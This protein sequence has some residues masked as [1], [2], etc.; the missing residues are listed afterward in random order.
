M[1]K[2]IELLNQ[3]NLK[4]IDNEKNQRSKFRKY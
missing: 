1:F 2:E 3:Y 4:N